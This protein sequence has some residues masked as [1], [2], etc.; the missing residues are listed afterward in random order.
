MVS[1][2]WSARSELFEKWLKSWLFSESGIASLKRCQELIDYSLRAGSKRF[3]PVLMMTALEMM[4]KKVEETRNAAIAIECIHTY[5]LIHD[6]L[7]CMDDDDY[8]RGRLTSH[9]H[10]GEAQAVL[11][12]DGLLTM[13]FELL[14]TMNPDISGPLV[15]ELARASG[16]NGM[17]AGQVLDM[18][19]T[20]QAG[21]IED[22]LNIHNR[23]TGALISASLAMAGIIAQ[24]SPDDLDRLRVLGLK[25]GLIFQVQDDILD[26]VADPEKLGK[27]VGKD[28]EQ[29]KLTYPSLLGLD[30]ARAYLHTLTSEVRDDLSNCPWDTEELDSIVSYLV[31]R[32]K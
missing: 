23:K 29:G 15:V 18:E 3:R 7:P 11:A 22:L 10:F 32:E 28:Q 4:G 19:Q 27:S 13:A 20:G 30:G 8:R 5:S 16:I 12:G 2:G 26:M 21:G 9:K 25:I 14:G 17:V 1:S 6:D 31:T 24:V